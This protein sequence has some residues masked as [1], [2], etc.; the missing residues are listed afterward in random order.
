MDNKRLLL[1][2]LLLFLA[3]CNVSA[4]KYST[5]TISTELLA[6]GL[7]HYHL[8]TEPDQ[9]SVQNIQIITLETNLLSQSFNIDRIHS[10]KLFFATS[11]KAEEHEALAAINGGFFDVVKGGSISFIE[12]NNQSVAI[13]SKRIEIKQ[14]TKQNI[15]GA[16]IFT[17][18][19]D[20][21]IERAKPDSKYLDSNEEKW[22]LL[23]GPLLLKDGKKTELLDNSFVN[24]RHPRT[25][26]AKTEDDILFITIDGRHKE[27]SGMNLLELQDYLIN[28]GTIDA[29]NL[30]GG[31]STTMWIDTQTQYGVV[32][33]PSDNKKFDHLGERKV[34]NAI[35][36]L[37]K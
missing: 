22:V 31:G 13:R 18:T 10:D 5:D 4:Q 16:L 28:L 24:K 15:N 11:D 29:I 23:A 36:I 37:E 8:R 12:Y 9:K 30:D 19:G 35:L 21:L 14:N 7:K 1:V 6:Q 32:N 34:A 25:I 27:A 20:L 2:N 3:L 17:Q 33:C 26:V